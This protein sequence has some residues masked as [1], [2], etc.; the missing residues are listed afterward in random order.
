MKKQLI[1]VLILILLLSLYAC[2]TGNQPAAAG[3]NNE[4]SKAI[5]HILNANSYDYIKSN[6]NLNNSVDK[7]VISKSKSEIKQ[8]LKPQVVWSKSENYYKTVDGN[9]VRSIAEVYYTVNDNKI[10]VNS[11]FLQQK[12][13]KIDQESTSGDWQ[14]TSNTDKAQ[15]DSILGFAKNRF[16]AQ[17]YLL[18]SNIDSFKP[19]KDP[20]AKNE[21]RYDG[22]IASET[23]LKAY[24]LY[25]RDFYVQMGL[26]QQLEKPSLEDLKN[27]ILSS[28]SPEIQ[29]GVAKLTFS[30]KPIPISI[31]I[32][33]DTSDLTKIVVDE[34]SVLQS[35]LDKQ[36]NTTDGKSAVVSKSL[37]T[38]EIIGIDT[39]KDIPIPK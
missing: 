32:S 21:T 29:S 2:G 34:S 10:E 11:R 3:D 37:Y 23:V 5:E 18:S 35:I 28:Q 31:W 25:E 15:V 26:L 19:V 17:I 36:V 38:Y 22:F 7:E 4:I 39:L 12:D 8:L 20:E 30:D 33:E 14:K 27:E 16:D 9:E 1:L 6:E 24:Q 13:S